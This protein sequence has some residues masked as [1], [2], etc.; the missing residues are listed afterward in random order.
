M[1]SAGSSLV[2]VNG[3]NGCSL[4]IHA[5]PDH[6]TMCVCCS[7]GEVVQKQQYI[8]IRNLSAYAG[9]RWH[10]WVSATTTPRG[11][12]A[13]HTHRNHRYRKAATAKMGVDAVVVVVVVF[14]FTIHKPI[15]VLVFTS[16]AISDKQRC[17]TFCLTINGVL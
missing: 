5:P 4:A 8:S 11:L 1:R 2:K 15:K 12:V 16:Y 6:V 17:V 14:V 9:D 13:A 3:G 10:V 7:C